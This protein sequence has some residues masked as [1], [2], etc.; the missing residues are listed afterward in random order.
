MP[1]GAIDIVSLCLERFLQSRV[2]KRSSHGAGEFAG[3]DEPRL[4][5]ILMFVAVKHAGGAARYVNG[6]WS[7]VGMILPLV[8]RY[9]RTA[10][11]SAGVM[12]SFLDLCERAKQTYPAETLGDQI[13]AVVADET[14]RL[15]GWSGTFLAARVAGLVQFIAD[16]ETPMPTGLAQKL[17]RILDLLVDMGDRRSAALQLSESFREVTLK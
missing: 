2:F 17:L 3:F 14:Q 13:L 15:R 11:W 16:R 6:D 10:G 7:E 5:E 12:N 1:S 4:A 9:V 8:D